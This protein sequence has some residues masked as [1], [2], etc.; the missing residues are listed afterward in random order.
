MNIEKLTIGEA[1]ETANMINGIPTKSKNENPAI[2]K[3]CI[4]RCRLT[5]V[6]AGTVDSM[7]S[8]IL[9]L[10][11]SRRL[12]QW[13]SAFTLSECAMK[14][15]NASNSKIACLV[16]IVIIP[17]VDIGEIIPC[18]SQAEKSI[19]EAKEYHA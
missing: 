19:R 12:W 6:H 18:T 13:N 15:I 9:V 16:D 5:G 3:Y 8:N 17:L 1:R 14:G 4:V 10:K 11:D 7:D 2:G